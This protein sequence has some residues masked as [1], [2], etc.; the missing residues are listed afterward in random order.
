MKGAYTKANNNCN[1]A[2]NAAKRIYDNKVRYTELKAGDRVLVI[3]VSVEVLESCDLTGRVK[4]T[5]KL[6]KKAVRQANPECRT[7]TFFLVTS[8][9][10][11]VS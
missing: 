7:E 5:K 1:R 10:L 6:N 3:Y 4:Y 8:Y 9:Y 11:V 2:A